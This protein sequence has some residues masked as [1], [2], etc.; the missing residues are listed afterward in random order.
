MQEQNAPS[1]NVLRNQRSLAYSPILLR[2]TRQGEHSIGRFTRVKTGSNSVLRDFIHH[3]L[4]CISCFDVLERWAD[5]LFVDRDRVP[6]FRKE[7][8][9]VAGPRDVQL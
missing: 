7:G 3:I 8:Y 5:P 9:I 4:D 2:R 1:M 6:P